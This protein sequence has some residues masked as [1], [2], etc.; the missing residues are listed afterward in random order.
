ML[1]LCVCVYVI[2]ELI[3]SANMVASVTTIRNV[4]PEY[5]TST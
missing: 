5:Q 1:A 2:A 4:H 3:M